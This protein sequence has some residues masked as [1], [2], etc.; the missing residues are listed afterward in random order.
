MSRQI[1]LQLQAL[2]VLE[3]ALPCDP[4]DDTTPDLFSSHLYGRQTQQDLKQS[5]T[6][7]L[8]ASFT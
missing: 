8:S 5:K 1:Q 2:S 7:P 6:V 3:Q 4:E